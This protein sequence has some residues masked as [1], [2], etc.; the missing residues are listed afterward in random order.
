MLAILAAYPSAAITGFQNGEIIFTT[1]LG[2]LAVSPAMAAFPRLSSLAGA[3]EVAQAKDLLWRMLLRLS[4]PLAFAAAMMVALAPWLVG[5]LYAITDNFSQANREFTTQTV[6]ALGFALLPWGLNQL[7]L[8]GFYAVGQVSAAVSVTVMVALLN[9]FGYWLLREQGLFLLNLATAAAGWI[10]FAVYLR[11]LQ[12]FSMVSQGQVWLQVLKVLVAALPAGAVAY[13]VAI[14]FG[15]P[16]FFLA[17]LL[18]LVAGGAAG[19]TVFGVFAWA[20]KLPLRLR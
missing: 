19:L 1:L 18:P 10:G 3:G 6:A 20:L 13:F 2:L 11:R 14:Q 9:T 5:G 7:I 15:V 16:K 4:V 17:N 8:R 12:R